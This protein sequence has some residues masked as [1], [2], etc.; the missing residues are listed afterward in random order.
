MSDEEIE[1]TVT[2]RLFAEK[3]RHL[4]D[5][6]TEAVYVKIFKDTGHFNWVASKRAEALS[7]YEKDPE[8][9]VKKGY[10]REVINEIG[11]VVDKIPLYFWAK[12]REGNPNKKLGEDL[13][14]YSYLWNLGGIGVF[15]KNVTKEK[16]GKSVRIVSISVGNEFANPNSDKFKEVI[17]SEWV[18]TEFKTIAEDKKN[19]TLYLEAREATNLTNI[20]IENKKHMSLLNRISNKSASRLFSKQTV[21]LKD[22]KKIFN[23]KVSWTQ[24][25]KKGTDE[26]FMAEVF[27]TAVDPGTD[28]I[29]PSIAVSHPNMGYMDADGNETKPYKVWWNRNLPLDFGEGTNMYLFFKMQQVETKVGD[30]WTGDWGDIVFQGVG[31][32]MIT[33]QKREVPEQKPKPKPKAKAEVTISNDLDEEIEEII[34][35]EEEDEDNEDELDEEEIEELTDLDDLDDIFEQTMED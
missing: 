2:G 35:D 12:N 22:I 18:K 24:E 14:E 30:K 25:H 5:I 17:H 29:S 6:G 33:K 19:K 32:M 10:V 3:K 23:K 4:S 1:D 13:P 21:L 20:N 26:E 7:E 31:F 9:A 27:V 16:L 11:E 8:N 28:E 34:E 15:E